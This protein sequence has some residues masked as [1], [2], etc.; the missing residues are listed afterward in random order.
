MAPEAPSGYERKLLALREV[1]DR[2]VPEVGAGEKLRLVGHCL[3]GMLGDVAHAIRA[4]EGASP[5]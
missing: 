2:L 1:A 4:S 5:A 3:D